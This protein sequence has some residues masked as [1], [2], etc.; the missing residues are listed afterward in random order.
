MAAQAAAHGGSSVAWCRLATGYNTAA[1]VVEMVAD[2]AGINLGPAHQVLALADQLLDLFEL[3]DLTVVIDEY[4]LA[5][6]GD[7]DRVIAECAD[8]LPPGGRVIV[9]GSTRPAG[10]IGLVSP[11][12][13]CVIDA[14]D[15]AFDDDEARS[16]FELQGA[17]AEDSIRWNRQLG[18]WAQGIAAGAH[19][20]DSDPATHVRTLLDQ[21]STSESPGTELLDALASLTYVTPEVLAVLDI[22]ADGDML[23]AAV[24]R[25]PLLVDHDGY[26][27]M[28]PAAAEAHRLRIEP[29]RVSELR[30]SA[31]SV[32]AIDDPTTA[33]ELLLEA[34]E[35]NLAADVLADH[36]SEIGVE[37]ALN[38]LYR[39][40]ADL[41][42]RFPP[43]LAAGQA[44]VEVD[45][46][47]AVAQARVEDATSE[48]SRREA[49]FAL[50][51]IESH[52][53]ELAAAAGALEAAL[54]SARDDEVA[55]ARISAELAT[56]R[57][58]LGDLIG[59]R[60]AIDDA[61]SSSAMQWLTAQ[62]DVFDEGP[63]P[64]A[65]ADLN[66]DGDA[67]REAAAALL[68]LAV[69]DFGSADTLAAAAYR[70]G[71][72]SGGEP[73]VAA[74]VV[75]AWSMIG[76]NDHKGA[77]VVADEM[78]RR[79]GPRHQLSRVHG[80][81]IRERCSRVAGALG[82]HERD[83]RRL[84]DL[85]GRGY[86]SIEQLAEQVLDDQGDESSSD[87][88]VLEVRVIGRHE[89]LCDGRIIG[90][91]EW[92]SKKALEVLTVLSSF[93][94]AGGRREQIV[95][96]V[97]PGREPEK[98]RTLLRTA[99][100]DIRRVLEPARPA[101][102]ASRFLTAQDDIIVLDG[103]LDLDRLDDVASTD[104]AV[105]FSE[106]NLGVAAAVVDAEWAQEWLPRVERLTLLAASRVP[107]NAER[108]QRI[109][110]LEALIVAE[111]WQRS[112]YDGLADLLRI[113]G[114]EAKAAEVERRWFADD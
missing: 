73:F 2:T 61:E 53:G 34:G 57:W 20:P 1:D 86:A 60:S 83:Q 91:S 100:S 48:R 108:P 11:S 103:I 68:A 18:G 82:E 97:W 10:L 85:R 65:E 70:S 24:D 41:R 29:E 112:H 58:L 81:I 87:A 98:G 32:V 94:S 15:L 13:L 105:A 102:E 101:G 4:N 89:V 84:R 8:L 113:A 104:P 62:L 6:D 5:A 95:E 79:L 16:L 22:D 25:S 12:K 111:P 44:T 49:L 38:W 7:L 78:E 92:K 74:S 66:V 26:V 9:A 110:A 77:L 21:L 106:L 27:R 75:R 14:I 37:R 72:E 42:H 69:G 80:A 88:P 31:A 56:T 67:Y 51:S 46:A 52:R 28:A 40:P 39:L 19:A 54:R 43:V 36:L 3:G 50:G 96:A 55:A 59:A 45:S 35:S 30:V 47:L 63:A 23:A 76:G 64:I 71:V 109:E 17:S 93:G 99:L 114:D 107:E 90:R 33:I